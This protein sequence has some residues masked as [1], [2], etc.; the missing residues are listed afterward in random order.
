M[1][2]TL[3]KS[4]ATFGRVVNDKYCRQQEDSMEDGNGSVEKREML[5]YN[6]LVHVLYAFVDLL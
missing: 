4:D 6:I 2:M 5:R 3:N 1:I